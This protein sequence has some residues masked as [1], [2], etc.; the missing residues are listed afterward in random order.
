MMRDR[1]ELHPEVRAA[2]DAGRP[3]VALESTILAHGMPYPENLETARHLDRTIRAAGAVPATICVLDGRIR[4]GLDDEDLE[5]L[6]HGR[7]VVK[8]SRR[9]LPIAVARGLDGATTVAAT[10]LVAASAAIEVFVTG[11]I[12]GVHRGAGQSFDVSADLPELA[13]SR[14][15]VVCAGAKAILDIAATLEYLETWGVPVLGFRTDRFPAF[16][17]RDSGFGVDCRCDSVADLAAIIRSKWDLG[18]AGGVVVANPIPERHEL[19]AEL[20]ERVL[21][22]ALREAAEA[23]VTGQRLTP[24]LLARCDE[25][26]GGRCL[27]ANVELVLSNAELG[28]RLARELARPAARAS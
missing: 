8:V 21:A 28:A 2:L 20:L 10:M 19:D 18:L 17:R 23:G 6:G 25:L 3:V 4:V 22:D 13:T 9:D 27:R 7:G 15:A 5:R 16:Y 12:G 26:S 14:V 24:F 1:L 11:G